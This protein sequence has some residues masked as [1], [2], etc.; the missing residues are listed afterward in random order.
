MFTKEQGYVINQNSKNVLLLARAG[1]GKTFTVANKIAKAVENGL[2]PEQVL[3]LTFTVKG[4]GELKE[5]VQ[6]Y[7]GE[8]GVNV[9]TIHSFCYYIIKDYLKQNG[10]FKEPNIADEVD[11]GEMLSAVLKIYAEDGL[12]ELSDGLPLLP[13]RELGKIM[14]RIK[15]ERDALGFKYSSNDG[16]GVATDKLFAESSSFNSLFSVKKQGV[17]ITDYSLIELLK[18]KANEFC[19]SYSRALEIANLLDFDDLIFYAKQ[20]LSSKDYKKPVYKLIIVDEMQD[21]SLLEYQVARVFFDGATVLMCGDPYQTIYSW[22]GSSPT[23]I[24]QDFIKGYG[25]ET[26]S[27][28]GNRRSSPLLT[29]AGERYLKET[30]DLPGSPMP[31]EDLNCYD[32]ISVVACYDETDEADFVFDYLK[33][34]GGDYTGVCVMARA[35][36]YLADLYKKLERKN[37]A[38]EKEERIAFFTADS[39]FQFYKKP[40]IKDFLGFLRLIVNPQ[41]TASFLRIAERYVKGVGKE[42]VAAIKDF[43][44]YGVSLSSF[45]KEETYTQ[46]DPYF[47]LMSAYKSKNVVIY[48]LETT[49]LNLEEDEM[50]QISALRL[51]DGKRFNR[52]VLPKGEI[53]SRAVLTHGYDL[54]HIKQNGGREAKEA[55]RDFVEF[56]NG[57]ILVG[58]NSSFYDDVMLIRQLDEEQIPYNFIGFFD[59]LVLAQSVLPSLSNYKLATCCEYFGVVNQRAHDALADVEATAAVFKRLLEDFYIPQTDAR[60][61]VVLSKKAK[62][63]DFYSSF[64]QMKN[65]LFKGEILK[66]IKFIDGQFGVLT[67]NGRLSDRESANDLYRALK[68]IEGSQ[69]KVLKLRSFLSDASLSGSQLDV[70]IKKHGKIP[71]ITIHQSKGCEFDTVILVGAGENEMPSYGARLSGSEDE[72]KRIFYVALSRAK[73]RFVLT[74]PSKKVYG[75]NVYDRKPSP[76]IAR[77]PKETVKFIQR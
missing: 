11:V 45:L 13:E 27:L 4:A 61:R 22:R 77:I 10:A 15:H 69:N 48:D 49:G 7:C 19:R 31:S 46:N 41:D 1:S 8:G 37:L 38:L 14:S 24:M 58:H 6:R 36:R 67:R 44:A 47:K 40:V 63:Q 5:D 30:F 65:M 16:Y 54:T 43:G 26:V 64:I 28:I 35:N 59:T 74:Y 25:A 70:I 50:I 53:S 39:D 18:K 72:E 62:F 23:E 66:L 60:C 57:C 32:K 34:Y 17:K 20:I 51:S 42:T 12:Y 33:N 29:Y 71:L 56:A 73:K 76:Y 2:K 9:F 3:C 75:Q 52:F 21:T 68:V 55:L